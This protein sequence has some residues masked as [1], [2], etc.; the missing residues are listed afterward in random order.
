MIEIEA[1]R[2]LGSRSSR[3]GSHLVAF[4][5]HGSRRHMLYLFQRPFPQFKRDR[6]GCELRSLAFSLGPS[7]APPRSPRSSVGGLFQNL[8]AELLKM[9]FTRTLVIFSIAVV[10]PL[11]V[12]VIV[13][14][15]RTP[16]ASAIRKRR[17]AHSY[18]ATLLRSGGSKC[19]RRSRAMR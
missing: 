13:H 11:V 10:I 18:S 6:A 14:R 15:T 17:A 12:I 4:L 7:R 3:R 2:G 9:G 1:G 8:F 19:R 16:N 5:A